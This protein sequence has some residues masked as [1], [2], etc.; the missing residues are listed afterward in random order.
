M[1]EEQTISPSGDA[2]ATAISWTGGKDC[3]LALLSAWRNPK[4]SVTTLVD[5][6][7]KDPRMVSAFMPTQYA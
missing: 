4:L 2:E 3:N 6:A 7:P 5:F 1:R